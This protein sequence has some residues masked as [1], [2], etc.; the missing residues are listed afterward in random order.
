MGTAAST[1]Y[2]TWPA[3]GTRAWIIQALALMAFRAAET[4]SGRG[5]TYYIQQDTLNGSSSGG[6]GAGTQGSPW[7]VRNIDDLSALIT[8]TVGSG[9]VAYLMKRGADLRATAGGLGLSIDW[10]NVTLGAWGSG[11]DPIYSGFIDDDGTS[12]TST[13]TGAYYKTFTS[14]FWVRKA[15]N[16][17]TDLAVGTETV[18]TKR[19]SQATVEANN[20]SW[21]WDSGT[22]R[23][24]VRIGA[25]VDPGNS[26]NFIQVCR[27]DSFG[28]LAGN[29]DNIR[30]ENSMAL[31]FGMGTVGSQKYSLM[32]VARDAN[33]NVFYNC[34]GYYSGHH[35][36]GHLVSGAGNAGGIS[37]WINCTWGLG[38]VDAAGASTMFVAFAN[39]GGHEFILRGCRCLYGAL[40]DSGSTG[41]SATTVKRGLPYYCHTVGGGATVAL[42]LVWDFLTDS[43]TYSCAQNGAMGNIPAYTNN[44][45]NLAS[46]RA[47]IHRERFAGGSNTFLDFTS[48]NVIFG[49]CRYVCTVKA[50][51]TS[52]PFFQ[53]GIDL[54]MTFIG[55]K[56]LPDYSTA[57]TGG[58]VFRWLTTT[59]AMY[60]DFVH[61]FFG[62]TNR[63]DSYSTFDARNVAGGAASVNT[64]WFNSVW[65][66]NVGAG[67]AHATISTDQAPEGVTSDADASVTGGIRNCAFYNPNVTVA[68]TTSGGY[69][70]YSASPGF[71]DL[72]ALPSA[73]A[74]PAAGGQLFEA[75]TTTIPFTME[76]WL[77]VNGEIRRMPTAPSIGAEQQ[78]SAILALG[79]AVSAAA[80]VLGII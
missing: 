8:N 76:W 77:D 79:G 21:W 73:D 49:W 37:T 47:W 23:L 71:V 44:R 70:G 34:H 30:I 20:N 69:Q 40:P 50:A 42:A 60:A 53:T 14:A 28:L 9:N 48:N 16:P 54:A 80:I 3:Y 32:S 57:T 36:V 58:S 41:W 2:A 74:V 4:P 1:L 17:W 64:R 55:C 51:H 52:E 6:G 65:S 5:T 35:V 56:F 38:R 10:A 24:Y 72:S 12:W 62:G 22:N 43:G 59:N 67:A 7:L 13:G 18:F 31:G 33:T 19:T 27:C 63:S 26:D 66:V 11:N 75:G 61:C 15:T 68:K 78:A 25:N 29:A 45:G 46:Y 39:D